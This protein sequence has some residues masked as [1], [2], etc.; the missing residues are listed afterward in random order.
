GGEPSAR[1]S[2][3]GLCAG[4]RRVL[5]AREILSRVA[6][7]GG[8]APASSGPSPARLAVPASVRPRKNS[9]RLIIASAP[10]SARPTTTCWAPAS[11]VP[12]SLEHCVPEGAEPEALG[13][14]GDVARIDLIPRD[15]QD[16]DDVSK[17]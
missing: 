1:S 13:P 17:M 15:P 9:R 12:G 7:G 6:S 10:S 3:W 5:G 16:P 11:F 8:S 4:R 14:L 2:S